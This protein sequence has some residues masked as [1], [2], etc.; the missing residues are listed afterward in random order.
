[1]VQASPTLAEYIQA[2]ADCL[3]NMVVTDAQGT[4]LPLN[5][6]SPQAVDILLRAGATGKIMVIGNGGSAAIAS[7][8]H[9]DLCKG[10]GIKALVFSEPPLLTALTNDLSYAE[11]FERQVQMWATSNDLLLAISSSGQSENILRAV[12]KASEQRCPTITFTGFLSTNPLRQMGLL[13]F[14][15]QSNVYGHVE[16]SHATLLHYLTDTAAANVTAHRSIS[17]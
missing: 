8:V 16:L 6:A 11:A 4:S 9:N 1:M 5:I 10:V 2:L 12:R 7:H 14:Y 3:V 17:R 15:V 13:N